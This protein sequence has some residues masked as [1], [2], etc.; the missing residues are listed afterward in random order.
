[1]FPKLKVYSDELNQSL[2]LKNALEKP[3]KPVS[4]N[5]FI[6]ILVILFLWQQS[7]L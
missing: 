7:I 6:L 5:K 2:I 3:A 1:M 4:F